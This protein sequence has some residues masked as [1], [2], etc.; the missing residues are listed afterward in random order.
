MANERVDI[1]ALIE[2]D[3]SID[4]HDGSGFIK[5]SP[6]KAMPH[7]SLYFKELF[8]APAIA[9]TSTNGKVVENL[10]VAKNLFADF[11][12]EKAN[13]TPSLAQKLANATGMPYDFWLRTQYR[14]DNSKKLDNNSMFNEWRCCE[15][16]YFLMSN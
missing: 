13:V 8:L 1:D 2:G 9:S 12:A 16:V 3:M 10:D 5:S 15:I 4:A 6:D 11:L 14:Y 7:P